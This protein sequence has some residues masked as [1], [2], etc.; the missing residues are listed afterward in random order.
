MVISCDIVDFI[1]LLIS[2]EMEQVFTFFYQVNAL[3]FSI[4]DCVLQC[5]SIY[6]ARLITI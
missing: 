3:Q 5:L 4:M 1:G 6:L 2:F